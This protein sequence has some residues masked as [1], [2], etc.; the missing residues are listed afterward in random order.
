MNPAE[1][2][3]IR[4]LIV[5]DHK[6]VRLGLRTLLSR[7]AGVEVVGEAGSVAGAVEEATR[8]Q[9]DVVLMDIRLP[10]GNGFEACR[11]IRK[12]Q[13]ETRVLFLTSV[14]DEEI[15]LESIDAGGDGY[16]L[17]EIDEENLV[18]AIRNVAA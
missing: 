15:V 16:L 17:K 14:A 12:A 9:P 18:G 11:Q 10:D 3:P 5:D 8:L 2:T 4:L 1:S 6:V 7:H 13:L